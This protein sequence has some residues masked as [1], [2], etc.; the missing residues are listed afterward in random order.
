[1]GVNPVQLS[2][3]NIKQ[4]MNHL[5]KLALPAF[6]CMALLFSCKDNENG[7]EL[8]GDPVIEFTKS[9]YTVKIGN[10]ITIEPTI[11]NA[12]NPVYSWKLDGKIISIEQNLIFESEKIDENFITLRV[13]ADNGSAEKQIKVSVVDKLPPQINLKASYTSFINV[14]VSIDPEIENNEGVTYE[15]MLDGNVISQDPVLVFKQMEVASYKVILSA[16]NEDGTSMGTTDV[17]LLVEPL[18][19]LYFDDGRY[20]TAVDRP[21]RLSVPIGRSLV[22]APVKV[23][24]SDNA[25]YQWSVDGAVQSGATK[26]IFTFTPIYQGTYKVKVTATDGATVVSGEVSVECVAAEG[27]HYRPATNGSASGANKCYGLV[28]AP[29]QFVNIDEGKSEEEITEQATAIIQANTGGWCFSLGAFGGYVIMGFDHSVDNVDGEADIKINGNAF[30]G[31]S[32]P[33]IVYVM[34]DENGNGLPDDM[35]Y[36]LKGSEYGTKQHVARLALTYFRPKGREIFWIDNL[37]NTGAG[38][39]LSGG[40]TKYPN[41]VKGDRVT[42]IG[43]CLQ[44]TLNEDGIITNPG[45]AWGYVDNV[46][47]RTGFY[48]EDAVQADGSPANLKYIDFV[49][50]HTGMNVDAKFLGEVSTETSSAFDMHLR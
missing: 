32:E 11:G 30:P 6:L 44:T 29:G 2:I 47:S 43:T 18:P 48:I 26:D 7:E 13:D 37:G 17:I 23:V 50:V 33:G 41:F 28:Q 45:Y 19:A 14:E 8:L 12:L 46:N 34:Q 3:S 39:A 20:R 10:N 40:I 4:L 49:K 24:I 21:I 42:F 16:T 1:M 9:E 27:T 22:L 36:E 38:A 35:W 25:T 31:W 15:W 5:Y